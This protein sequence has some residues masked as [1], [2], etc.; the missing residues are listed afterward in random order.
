M[1]WPNRYKVGLVIYFVLLVS[2]KLSAQVG[3]TTTEVL[4]RQLANIDLKLAQLDFLAN[5]KQDMPLLRELEFRT[6]TDEWEPSRQ[7]IGF[8]L[9]FNSLKMR[10]TQRAITTQR[11]DYYTI[12]QQLFMEDQL[13]I[14]YQYLIDHYY[15]Q[16]EKKLNE[17]EK[18][19]LSD[20]KKVYERMLANAVVVDVD[21]VLGAERD[22]QQI[23]RKLLRVNQSLANTAGL[24]S[25]ATETDFSENW[26]S[27]AKMEELVGQRDS[28]VNLAQ[29]AQA[30]KVLEAELESEMEEREGK[31]VLNFLSVKQAGRNQLNLAREFS[32]GVGLNIPLAS[33]NRAKRNEAILDVLDEEQQLADLDRKIAERIQSRVHNFNMALEEYRLL[34]KLI[35]T[36]QLEELLSNYQVRN[37]VHPLNLLKIKE[38]ILDD[39]QSLL[40]LEEK[41]CVQFLEILY[42]RGQLSTPIRRNYLSEG[43]EEVR[44]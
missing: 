22:L 35:A 31:Q 24:L 36:S 23:E 1:M 38:N 11:T 13:L 20:Q 4:V 37:D 44:F 29:A 10:A 42:Y 43:L 34:E 26:I 2:S 28:V 39:R 15:L 6:E 32:V 3:V 30:Q 27:L 33:N 14:T 12:R 18:E 21:N 7:E 19:V 40:S 41:A 5:E 16:R 9:N 17:E 8:R 25:I